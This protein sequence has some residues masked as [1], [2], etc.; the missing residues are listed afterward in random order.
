MVDTFDSDGLEVEW[1]CSGNLSV[2]TENIVHGVIMFEMEV[3]VLLEAIGQVF[4][5]RMLWGLTREEG[6]CLG[7]SLE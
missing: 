3:H 4:P 6:K 1:D 5:P 7:L 2:F